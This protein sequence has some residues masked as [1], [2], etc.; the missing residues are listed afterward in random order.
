MII[1]LFGPPAAGKTTFARALAARLREGGHPVELMLSYRP[2]ENGDPLATGPASPLPMAVMRRFTRPAIEFLWT[3]GHMPGET[4][5]TDT[6]AA[7]LGILTPRSLL[8]SG[9][10]RQ[11]ITRL[12]VAWRRAAQSKRTVIVDQGFVQAVCSLILLGR[13][14]QPDLARQAL[15]LIPRADLLIR[16]AAPREVLRARLEAR[17]Q[18][19]SWMEK[20]LEL[21]TETNLSSIEIVET[22]TTMLEQQGQHVATI[23]RDGERAPPASM[24]DAIGCDVTSKLMAGTGA[25]A[26]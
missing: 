15:T 18:S 24:I 13:S 20:L 5:R 6:A 26:S 1:E 17:R 23:D 11:Y 12:D 3:A 9:R 16:L 4:G 22:L 10:L 14:P 25:L 7:L 2:S 21:D 19:Q 8:W